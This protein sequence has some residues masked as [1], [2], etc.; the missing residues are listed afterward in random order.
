MLNP[1]NKRNIWNGVL[2]EVEKALHNW[3]LEHFE[4]GIPVSLEMIKQK[5][6]E[7][8]RKNGGTSHNFSH[9]W[10]QKFKKRFNIDYRKF[11]REKKGTD[12]ENAEQWLKEQLPEILKKI[13]LKDIY[14]CDETGLYFRGIPNSQILKT[15]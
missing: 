2:H 15:F 1:G 13:D 4:Q 6:I 14:N 7:I 11:C 10:L 9:G 8:S 3:I 5:A 12:N